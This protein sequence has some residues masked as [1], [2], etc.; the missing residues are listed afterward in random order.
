MGSRVQSDELVG[1]LAEVLGLQGRG[2]GEGPNP[3]CV[4]AIN[5]PCKEG[6]QMGVHFQMHLAQE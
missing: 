2:K 6:H 4:E 3:P 1:E 5:D